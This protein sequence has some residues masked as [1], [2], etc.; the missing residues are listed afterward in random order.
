MPA[1]PLCVQCLGLNYCRQ[2]ASLIVSDAELRNPEF[3][4]DVRTHASRMAL[5]RDGWLPWLENAYR[6]YP[7]MIVDA[8]G[9]PVPLDL[10]VFETASIRD[11][12]RDFAV[13]ETPAH[14]R[15]RLR[16]EARERVLVLATL[17]RAIDPK[18]ASSWGIRAA[19]DN[20]RAHPGAATEIGC[21]HKDRA[22]WSPVPA[23]DNRPDGRDDWPF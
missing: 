4:R 13:R 2:L 3:V 8:S 17:L 12:F 7:G 16:V 21:P 22:A 15:P 9:D 5:T 10:S 1:F 11:W 19:N 20:A 14:V 6:D 23:N 18:A